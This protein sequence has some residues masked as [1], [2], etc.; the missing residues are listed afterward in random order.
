MWDR[1]SEDTIGKQLVCGADS[2]G[3]HFKEKLHFYYIAWG[4]LKETCYWLRRARNR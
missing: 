3:Y 2:R 1:F 4:S